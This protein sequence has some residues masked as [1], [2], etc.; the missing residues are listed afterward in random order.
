MTR[1]I[2]A[3]VTCAAPGCDDLVTRGGR[4]RPRIYCSLGCRQCGLRSAASR[5]IVE[6]DHEPTLDQT[7]AAGRIW[8]V[9]LRRAGRTVVI[10]EQLGRPSADHLPGQID[11][12]LNHTRA[13]RVA[14]E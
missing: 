6:V 5:L 10:A 4:G 9:R 7:R 8:I 3:T 2:P 11:A 13:D 1:S 14:M 12:L